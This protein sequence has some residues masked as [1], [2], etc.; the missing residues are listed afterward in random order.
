LWTVGLELEKKLLS[1]DITVGIHV[2]VQPFEHFYV[3]DIK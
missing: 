2:K 1:R 3:F